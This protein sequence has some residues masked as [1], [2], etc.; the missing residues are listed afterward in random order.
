MKW[1]LILFVSFY[2]AR[3]PA[4]VPAP[5]SFRLDEYD[6]LRACLNQGGDY[7]N[8]GD[9]TRDMKIEFRCEPIG[10]EPK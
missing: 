4:P 6:T 3:T 2:P 1:V 8:V 10:P 5:A 9:M 7:R